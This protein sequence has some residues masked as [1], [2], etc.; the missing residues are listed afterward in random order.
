M[1]DT[2]SSNLKNEIFNVLVHHDLQVK[3]MKGK[4]YDGASNIRGAWNGLQALI[5]RDCPYAYYVYC[6]AHRL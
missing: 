5:F 3:K 1:T 6:F 2:T 4:R